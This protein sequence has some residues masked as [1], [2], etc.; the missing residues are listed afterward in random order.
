MSIKTY[1]RKSAPAKINLGLEVLRKRPDGYH[2]INTFMLKITIFDE[3]TFDESDEI[4]VI[5]NPS[6]VPEKE[7]IIYKAANMLKKLKISRENNAKITLNKNIP[8]GAGLG[9]GSSDA[10]Q[11]ILALNEMWDMSLSINELQDTAVKL[12][13]DVPFF[14]REGSALAAG[15]G[16]I[17][18]FF[19]ID[20]PY[21]LLIVFPEIEVIT[22]EAY[23]A[24]NRGAAE[25]KPADLVKYIS[26]YNNKVDELRKYIFN[27]FEEYVFN[28]YPGI[29]DIKDKLYENGALFAML[30]GSGSAVY[31]LFE[32]EKKCRAAAGNFKEF[33]TFVCNP[34]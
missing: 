25:K 28:I 24:L 16:D 6:I 7:N 30:T 12:G 27:D 21:F 31:G 29:A 17:L 33:K 14:L 9:G 2:D 13:M 1:I 22:A 8:S 11:T 34:L 15:R 23:R 3:I 4:K 32:S 18:K 19:D 26:S 5:S 10:A 20:L